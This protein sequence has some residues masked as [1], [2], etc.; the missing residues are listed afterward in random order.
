MGKLSRKTKQEMPNRS[1]SDVFQVWAASVT[2]GGAI[3]RRMTSKPEIL[4]VYNCYSHFWTDTM[5][6]AQGAKREAGSPRRKWKQQSKE[7]GSLVPGGDV[8]SDPCW[9]EIK[10]PTDGSDV[11]DGENAKSGVLKGS[12][13]N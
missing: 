9:K 4:Q 1:T 11:W 10:E 13:F 12:G 5:A 8:K 2:G 7:R 3:D 6:A